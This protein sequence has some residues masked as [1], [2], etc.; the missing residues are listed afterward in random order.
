MPELVRRVGG[1]LLLIDPD[2]R[3]LLIH[4]RT[5]DGA[6]TFWITPGGG[7][8]PGETPQQAAVRETY[9]ET[10]I[11][12]TLLPDAPVAHSRVRSW[13]GDGVTYE[14]TEH[15]FTVSVAAG[16]TFAPAGL[17][18]VERDLWLGYRWWTPA[19]LRASDET[20]VPADVAELVQSVGP[21][22]RTAGRVL[23]LDDAGRVLLIESY[24]D[25]D[26]SSTHWITPGGG[27]EPGESPAD[28]A[29][30]ELL[31]EIGVRV[32]LGDADAVHIDRESFRFNGRV[33]EQT[34]HYFV[35]RLAA[36][37]SLVVAGADEVEQSVLIGERWWTSAELRATAEVVY[38][39]GLADLVESVVSGEHAAS[40]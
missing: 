35:V 4:E 11:E 14:Q 22:S 20:F 33:Y 8:E 31:E 7:L 13:S 18:D 2:G 5:D 27:A 25:V 30:R 17:T 16:L 29:A 23:L 28:A 9:E 26:T 1:R 21:I 32:E 39:V 6:A 37:T 19:E 12:I 38:P 24:V 3:L 34:N 15:F 10:G 36:G 40:A